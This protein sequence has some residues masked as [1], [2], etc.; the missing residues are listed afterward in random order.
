[1]SKR[2]IANPVGYDIDTLFSYV[3]S[4]NEYYVVGNLIDSTTILNICDF[5]PI[6]NKSHNIKNIMKINNNNS[7]KLIYGPRDLNKIRI[8]YLSRLKNTQNTQQLIQSI[9]DSYNIIYP[10]DTQNIEFEISSNDIN[11]NIKDDI[12]VMHPPFW[13][14]NT[15]I[16][17]KLNLLNNYKFLK[18]YLEIFYYIDSINL[19]FSIPYEY[20]TKY[21][22]NI[23]CNI[24]QDIITKLNS[25]TDMYELYN[26]FKDKIIQKLDN[27]NDTI[28]I[29]DIP[30]IKLLDKLAFYTIYIFYAML[31][32]PKPGYQYGY[33]NN[34][35]G[36][37]Y[38]LYKNPKNKFIDSFTDNDTDDTDDNIVTIVS[39]GGLNKRVAKKGVDGLKKI[40][41]NINDKYQL[42]IK[43]IENYTTRTNT[44]YPEKI[45]KDIIIKINKVIKEQK[46]FVEKGFVEQK[47]TTKTKKT[48]TKQK[49]GYNYDK[50]NKLDIDINQ[51]CNDINS[52]LK[53]KLIDLYDDG[54]LLL[55]SY[56]SS[57]YIFFMI[58][59]ENFICK[60][61]TK[62]KICNDPFEESNI[63]NINK[64][65]EY[66]SID[67]SPLA[68]DLFNLRYGEK[69][70]NC[71][72]NENN[73]AVIQVIGNANNY[74]KNNFTKHA[75]KNI[76]LYGATIDLY[77]NYDS[78]NISLLICLDNSVFFNSTLHDGWNSKAIFEYNPNNTD[79]NNSI[80]REKLKKYNVINIINLF[81]DK[82]QEIKIENKK[83]KN[84]INDKYLKPI[85]IKTN[86]FDANIEFKKIKDY[87][88]LNYYGTTNN[89]QIIMSNIG[90]GIP[91]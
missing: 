65:A 68:S 84:K 41:K 7:H 19:I 86:L 69:S 28:N 43:Y 35:R 17:S 78:K 44:Q 24:D 37:L 61:S 3:S 25:E 82:I 14:K 1:M 58:L 80:F 4:S 12:K 79:E 5:I 64:I 54:S 31:K 30:D 22:N 50:K 88:N 2:Y 33:Q 40:F 63:F 55:S 77:G 73:S 51:V 85:V 83:E 13:Y 60:D 89:K 53:Q 15:N 27:N 16:N 90:I 59:I 6:K 23:I 87:Y 49:G 18:R 11:D 66:S 26:L 76:I 72:V 52:F 70:T 34:I 75:Y 29:Y 91:E 10:G 47:D 57:T 20:L 67:F 8:L 56:P 45:M 48:K 36:A 71:F 46:G 62:D 81:T 21:N 32:P 42:Y 39:Y 38:N 9:E 74:S